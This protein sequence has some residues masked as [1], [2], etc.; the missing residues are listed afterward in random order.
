MAEASPGQF[1][2]NLR[3]TDDI[4]LA[5]DHALAL[6]RLVRL[7]AENHDMHATFMAKPY[8]DYAGSGMHVHVSMQDGR[9][10]TCSSTPKAR[11]HRY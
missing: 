7:V 8:E 10:T 11:I 9:A 1:E 6:K 5:C 4:L 2:V 3:H